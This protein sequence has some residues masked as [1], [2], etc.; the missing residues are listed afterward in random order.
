MPSHDRDATFAIVDALLAL[1]P[2]YTAHAVGAAVERPLARTGG[3]P[4][5]VTYHEAS[6]PSGPLA[7]VEVRESQSRAGMVLATFRDSPVTHIEIRDHAGLDVGSWNVPDPEAPLDESYYSTH[8]R[9]WG[10][11]R[12]GYDRHTRRFR[13]LILDAMKTVTGPSV[14]VDPFAL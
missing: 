10:D 4:H 6:F 9:P 5:V 1:D 3:H 12:I 11:I 7:R 14:P 8:V 2:P 13:A